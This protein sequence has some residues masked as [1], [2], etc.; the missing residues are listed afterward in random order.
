M[1]YQEYNQKALKK[2]QSLELMI[3]KDFIKVCEDN[4]LRYYLHYGSLL[5]AIR[6]KG[7]I[8][9]DDDLDV[10]MFREDYERFNQIFKDN[11]DEKYQLLNNCTEKEYFYLFSKLML[12]DTKCE[13]KWMSQL[14]FNI[15]INID[16]FV[17]DDLSNNKIKRFYQIKKTFLY[18]KLMIMSKVKLD[19]LPMHIRFISSF[20]HTFLNIFKITPSV[21]SKKYLN[22]LKKY[23]DKKS[24]LVFDN[25]APAQAYPQIFNRN[26]FEPSVKVKFED[27]EATVPKNYD[28]ILKNIYGDY[29]QLP[30][31]EKRYNH[32]ID[33]LD[34]GKY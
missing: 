24:N 12:K 21:I 25:S 4:D 17:L 23:G 3:L 27:I 22:F 19:D 14:N 20:T 5:G 26:D 11:F 31:K 15:G 30:P 32:S 8:P 18:N 9:W 10:L 33:N 1:K 29:M 13:E 6:H 16:I 2:L 7:F 34:F 28:K